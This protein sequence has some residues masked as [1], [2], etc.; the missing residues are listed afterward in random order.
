MDIFAKLG[1]D[2]FMVGVQAFNF[3]AL[4]GILSW[5]LYRPVLNALDA[6]RSRIESAEKNAE[7]IERQVKE[8]E[9][10]VKEELQKA[11]K[12]ARDIVENSRQTAKKVEEELTAAAQ[13]KVEKLLADAKSSIE[14]EKTQALAEM[15]AVAGRAAVAAAEKILSRE[16]KSADQDKLVAEALKEIGA[17]K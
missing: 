9:A 1:I 6:R 4:L 13:A 8:T 5:L 2:W 16:I 3:F 15:A 7:R 10:R 12:E 11:H 17:A 14:R